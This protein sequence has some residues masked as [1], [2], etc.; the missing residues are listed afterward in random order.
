M[1]FT[2][3]IDVVV[4]RA[5]FFRRI[6]AVDC[7]RIHAQETGNITTPLQLNSRRRMSDSAGKQARMLVECNQS[8]AFQTNLCIGT[9]AFLEEVSK[10]GKKIVV[11]SSVTLCFVG[12]EAQETFRENVV[13]TSHKCTFLQM[14]TANVERN[15]FRVNNTFD[16]AKPDRLIYEQTTTKTNQK[17]KTK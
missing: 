4:E 14:F 13:E 10:L 6:F 15:I 17:T 16:K 2:H 12:E 9:H 7:R 3:S 1:F 8:A 5:K 11:S